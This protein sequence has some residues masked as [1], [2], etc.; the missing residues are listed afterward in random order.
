MRLFPSVAALAALAALVVLG[1]P[2]CSDQ[3]GGDRTAVA[4]FYPLAYAA[5]RIADPDWEVIDLTPPGTEAHD[6]ELSLEDRAAIQDADL[7]IYLGDIGF[8]P[9][10]EEAIDDAEG[11]VVPAADFVAADSRMDPH[12]WLDPAHMARIAEAISSRLPGSSSRSLQRSLLA[13]R[14]RYG[15][16]LGECRYDIAIVPHEA[17]GYMA[18]AF[19]FEQFGL[20][21]LTPEGEATTARLAEAEGLIEEGQAGAVFYETGG[22]SQRGAEA[23][24]A[25]AGVPALP[26]STLESEPP[27]GD[28]LSVMEDN[29]DSLRQGLGCQ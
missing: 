23:L 17:F 2:G 29:L 26:L 25:D 10:V 22:E 1:L 8:Q 6:V 14:E 12:I 5:E 15:R 9:Q 13:L 16:V 19:G 20:A 11:E 18:D 7:V 4:S 24:A 3:S 27:E 21:G 28:Y